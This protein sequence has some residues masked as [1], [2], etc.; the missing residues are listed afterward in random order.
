MA[1]QSLQRPSITVDIDSN[2]TQS[3]L[4]EQRVLIVGEVGT[5]ATATTLTLVEDVSTSDS[6]TLFGSDSQLNKA[7]QKFKD[8]NA[9]SK[10]DVLPIATG[11]TQS[12]SDITI[13]NPATN[14]GT[15]YVSIGGEVVSIAVTN[16]DTTVTVATALETAFTTNT[17]FTASRAGNVVTLTSKQSTA[18]IN[19]TK[20][21]LSESTYLGLDTT[22]T[23]FSGGVSSTLA[24]STLTSLNLS[25][26]YQS[27]IT[28]YALTVT[29]ARVYTEANL[30]LVNEINDGI[31]FATSN[32]TLANAKTFLATQN[33]KTLCLFYNLDEMRYDV[34]PL[35][36]T[37]EIVA[38]RSLRLSDDASISDYV[39][40]SVESVGGMNKCSLPYFNTPL[41][42]GEPN[43]K[44]EESDL[45]SLI[46]AG[47]TTFT[48]NGTCV[49]SEVVTTYKTNSQGLDDLSWKYLNY[50]DTMSTVR[51]YFVTQLRAKYGQSRFTNGDL[52]SG[53]SMANKG[54]IKA[55]IT[56]LYG[57]LADKGTS[58]QVGITRA[59]FEKYFSNNLIVSDDLA[60]GT[61]SFT[62]KVPIVTQLRELNGVVEL[63]LT[64]EI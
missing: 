31:T 13:T 57:T 22:A 63:D 52:I 50:L 34:Y 21:F 7:V 35:V 42:F 4:S 51:E 6:V 23:D 9:Y 26:R 25:N 28:D 59:G 12:T 44:I 58:K 41:S 1:K 19:G 40:D 36:A 54:S 46:D 3:G 43:G 20:I 53:V 5:S 17:M 27:I 33:Y 49:L 64:A 32:T 29:H 8:I 30:N 38:I 56:R 45:V 47:G 62:A 14:T 48:Y 15:L 11:S 60:T 18:S 10:L 24:S 61:F 2:V 37:A 39:L 55:F 16:G